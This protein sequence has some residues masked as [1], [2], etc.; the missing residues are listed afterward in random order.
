MEREKE[1]RERGREKERR[2]WLSHRDERAWSVPHIPHIY[3]CAVRERAALRKR[4]SPARTAMKGVL[5]SKAGLR[6]FLEYVKL[7]G[8]CG[9]QK[10]HLGLFQNLEVDYS[11]STLNELCSGWTGI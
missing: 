2:G 7:K 1:Q 4:H 6:Q 10:L 5:Q 11:K 3:I 9:M 8:F